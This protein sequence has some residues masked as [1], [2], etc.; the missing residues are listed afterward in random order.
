MGL[1]ESNIKEQ[2][3]LYN[4]SYE[5]LQEK[6]K[7]AQDELLGFKRNIDTISKQM[8]NSIIQNNEFGTTMTMTS[9]QRE[10]GSRSQKMIL[11]EILEIKRELES[12]REMISEF[13]YTRGNLE[14]QLKDLE[15]VYRDDLKSNLE[16]TAKNDQ[17]QK[18]LVRYRES[19][20]KLDRLNRMISDGYE[21][22][23]RELESVRQSY[24]PEYVNT[25]FSD[26]LGIHMREKE[27]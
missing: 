22:T 19:Y 24:N 4:Q 12:Q 17:I 8:D 13:K 11:S 5:E 7:Q 25:L 16:A 18:T 9:P 6:H 21:K 27:I 20:N 23:K 2:R 14:N 10:E 1:L 26:N 3:E 15:R